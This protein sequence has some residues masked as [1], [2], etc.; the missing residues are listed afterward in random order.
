MKPRRY[1][2][3]TS[4]YIILVI[5]SLFILSTPAVAQIDVD[6]EQ[7]REHYQPDTWRKSTEPPVL[8]LKFDDFRINGFELK[9][10]RRYPATGGTNYWWHNKREN[11]DLHIIINVYQATN[12]AHE[13]LYNWLLTGI[14]VP[15]QKGSFSS[16]SNI[17]GDISWVDPSSFT[18]AFIRDNVVVIMNGMTRVSRHLQLI[19]DI[20]SSI[21]GTIKTMPRTPDAAKNIK[22]V[23]PIIDSLV[24]D[25]TS[26]RVNER[27]RISIAARDPRG[28]KLEFTFQ[29]TGGNI[30]TTK[31]GFFYE[32]TKP[33]KHTITA[34]A[35]NPYNLRSRKTVTIDVVK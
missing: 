10:K 27:T 28:G 29:A 14:N 6:N 20:A 19:E 2:K 13:G 31:E 26:L 15:M 30:L 21:D 17:I 22:Q 9:G 16:D 35:I 34:F 1:T 18:L 7:A 24:L 5:L 12:E 4:S 11:L 32:A 8:G 23:S 25:Q 33:G 3:K